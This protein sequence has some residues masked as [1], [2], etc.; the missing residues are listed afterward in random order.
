AAFQLQIHYNRYSQNCR[1]ASCVRPTMKVLRRPTLPSAPL[2][3]AY[4]EAGPPSIEQL[5]EVPGLGARIR[6]VR[7]A[8]TLWLRDDFLITASPA[9][10][11][12]ALRAFYEAA[13]DLPLHSATLLRRSGLVRHGVAHLLRSPDPLPV[14][15]GRCLDAAGPYYVAGLGP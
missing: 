10:F 4:A 13:V 11:Q 12:A 7:G 3:R 8:R 1:R 5:T 2:L 15:L 9:E 6:A 14:K